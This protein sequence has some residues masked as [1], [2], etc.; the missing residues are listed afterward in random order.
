MN[1]SPTTLATFHAALLL[2]PVVAPGQDAAAKATSGRPQY[3]LPPPTLANVQ[4]GP[5]ER[6]VL[7]FWQTKNTREKAPLLFY[8][9]GGAW[10]YGDKDSISEGINAPQFLDAGISVVSINYRY[11]RLAEAEGVKPPVIGPL[12]DAARA[13]QFVRSRAAEW[14]LDKTRVGAFGGSAG[15]ASSLW[16]ALHPDLADPSS[17]DPV[18]RESTRL[19]CAAVL[20]AQTT[21]DPQQIVTW[22]PNTVGYGAHA[23]GIKQD[24]ERK[25]SMLQVYVT[26]REKYLPWIAEYSPYALVSQDDPPLFLYYRNSPVPAGQPVKDTSHTANYGVKFADHCKEVGVDCLF[27]HPEVEGFKDHS[28]EKYLIQKLSPSAGLK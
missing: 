11:I 27:V 8:I 18:A 20:N 19:T 4:Y 25:L 13:L 22:I 12:H 21:L 17:S 2:A 26:D 14:K 24:R 28:V 16:L 3:V 9:H 7:D 6:Q 1:P 5:H 15:G 10:N 23:F